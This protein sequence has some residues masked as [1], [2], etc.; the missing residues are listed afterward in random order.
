M[1]FGLAC[2]SGAGHGRGLPSKGFPGGLWLGSGSHSGHTH[3]HHHVVQLCGAQKAIGALSCGRGQGPPFLAVA[4]HQGETR[5][6]GSL[7]GHSSLLGGGLELVAG[8]E[9]RKGRVG[10]GSPLPSSSLSPPPSPEHI[11][12]I[13]ASLLRNLRGQQRT[14]LLNK[15]TESDSE[16]VSGGRPWAASGGSPYPRG[17]ARLLTF[18]AQFPVLILTPL[19]K[20]DAQFTLALFCTGVRSLLTLVMRGLSPMG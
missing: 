16:K 18:H 5:R 6:L 15:F 17:R 20:F 3:T 1:D 12:S 2:L 9:P 19:L 11:C 7:W 4:S 10:K 8:K 13:L 14:R